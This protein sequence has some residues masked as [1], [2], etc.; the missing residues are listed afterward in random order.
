MHPTQTNA[1]T[2]GVGERN[3]INR[4]DALSKFDRLLLRAA[5]NKKKDIVNRYG[6]E[7]CAKLLT[8]RNTETK[9]DPVFEKQNYESTI[10]NL[11]EKWESF[12]T[13]SNT[14]TTKKSV[15]WQSNLTSNAPNTPKRRI[16]GKKSKAGN[17]RRH[18]LEV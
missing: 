11:L 14:E 1:K 10:R 4:N 18:S 6:S 2:E 9:D 7:A 17:S 8:K 3:S 12:T 5:E 15:T 16:A 13:Q